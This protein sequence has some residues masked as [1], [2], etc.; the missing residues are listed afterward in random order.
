[1]GILYS[2]EIT[3]CYSTGTTTGGGIVAA[4]LD[5]TVLYC[6]ASG[7]VNNST[8]GIAGSI[9]GTTEIRG[10]VALNP[11]VETSH[12]TASIGRVVGSAE[13]G[14]QLANIAWDGMIAKRAG[15][16]TTFAAVSGGGSVNGNNVTAANAILQN[17]YVTELWSFG[18]TENNPWRLRTS[19][20]YPLPIL[21]YQN[22]A[23]A[24]S[25]GH[26]N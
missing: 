3:N 19:Y 4:A 10:C 15:S 8:G 6:Y 20:G 22:A 25:I 17:T 14:S 1:V 21:Y 26:L 16:N 2:D 7:A 12:P 24:A 23:P 9:D 13:A 5:S 18:S 11:S